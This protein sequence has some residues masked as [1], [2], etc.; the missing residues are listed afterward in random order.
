M[1]LYKRPFFLRNRKTQNVADFS[2]NID[3]FLTK[4][5]RHF[6][7]SFS[8]LPSVNL[9]WGHVKCPKNI[10]LDRFSKYKYKRTERQTSKIC[11]YIDLY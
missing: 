7:P 3:R 9:P 11:I 4:M 6:F 5:Y 2:V 8:L 10:G 1:L